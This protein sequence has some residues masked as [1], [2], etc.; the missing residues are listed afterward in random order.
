MAIQVAPSIVYLPGLR[1]EAGEMISGI[2]AISGGVRHTHRR[3]T[4]D[5]VTQGLYEIS[6]AKIERPVGARVLAANCSESR[7][8]LQYMIES[9]MQGLLSRGTQLVQRSLIVRGSSLVISGIAA[10]G[11]WIHALKLPRHS[12]TIRPQEHRPEKRFAFRIVE[13]AAKPVQ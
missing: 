11:R 5:R 7:S 6:V 1:S 3:G 9:T 4:Q 8:C 12:L 2:A 10:I 13:L